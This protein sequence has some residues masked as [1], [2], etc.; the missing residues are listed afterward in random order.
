MSSRPAWSV[1]SN[2]QTVNSMRARAI[3]RDPASEKQTNKTKYYTTFN[4]NSH[5]NSFNE[6]LK[7][8]KHKGANLISVCNQV[9]LCSKSFIVCNDHNWENL[10]E[11]PTDF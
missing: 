6:V 7:F 1:V 2:L 11:S 9:Q 5:I 10:L 3:F 8:L 4:M